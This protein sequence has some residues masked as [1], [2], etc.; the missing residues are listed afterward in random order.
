MKKE[1]FQGYRQEVHCIME[2]GS[3]NERCLTRSVIKHIRKHNKALNT[4]AAVGNDYAS[5]NLGE[6]SSIV[7]SDG[8][9]DDPFLAWTKAL[10]NL[11]VSGGTIL[12]AR[13]VFLCPE[14]TKESQIKEYMKVFNCLADD[15]GIQIMGGHTE[16]SK[17]HNDISFV[18]NVLGICGSY[19]AKTKSIE[20]GFD[21]IMTKYAGI[22]G[23]DR[24]A[25]IIHD[26]LCGRFAKSYVESAYVDRNMFSIS[27]E[28]KILSNRGDVYYMHDVS[29]GGIYGALWQ[30][31][32]KINHGIEIRHNN[33]FIKQET[34]EIA[35]FFNI[36]P[37]MLDGTGSLI[38]VVE[39]GESAV[40]ELNEAGIPSAV[41]GKVS[42]GKERFVVIEPTGEKRFLSPVNGDEIYKIIGGMRCEY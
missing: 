10:N 8:V 16:I 3:V 11:A 31:G 17:A 38:A 23:G 15:S 13:I 5:F 24:L 18:V 35:E 14:N 29:C 40:N 20:P 7:W 26:Q 1:N 41:I 21:I 39:N 19:C 4:G 30:L 22:M 2:Q 36:N 42:S 12:G 34:I 9:S 25:R 6:N 33:I 32:S 28:A 37:Y 27:K